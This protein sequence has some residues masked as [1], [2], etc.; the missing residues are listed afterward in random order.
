MRQTIIEISFHM[1]ICLLFQGGLTFS[2]S[3][4]CGP[5]PIDVSIVNIVSFCLFRDE[6]NLRV[7]GICCWTQ[8]ITVNPA[9]PNRAFG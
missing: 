7:L 1:S 6:I 2:M 4:C 3:H 5:C 9:Q 8:S